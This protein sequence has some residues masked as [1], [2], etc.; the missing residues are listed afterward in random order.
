MDPRPLETKG[1]ADTGCL[2]ENGP[3]MRGLAFC[4]STKTPMTSP[5]Q[6]QSDRHK[7]CKQPPDAR[8]RVIGLDVHPDSFA[9]AILAGRD[10]LTARVTHSVTGAPLGALEAW[11]LRHSLPEDILVIEASSN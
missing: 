2:L 9:A 5:N 11:A 7:T 10:P 1:E 6:K 8:A 4:S 3:P